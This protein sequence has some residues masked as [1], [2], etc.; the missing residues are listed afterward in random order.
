MWHIALPDA[1]PTHQSNHIG[2]QS[3]ADLVAFAHATLYSPVL[4]TLEKALNIGWLTN[5][6]GLSTHTLRKHPP[7]STSTTKGHMDQARMNQRS[8]RKVTTIKPDTDDPIHGTDD[9][10]PEAIPAKTFE[11]FCAITEPTGQIYTDQTGRFISPSSTGNNYLMILYDYDSNHIFA[12][13]MKNQQA[14]TIVDAYAILHARLCKDGLKPRLQR[15]DNECSALLKE[16]MHANDVDFQLVPPG[17]H[18]RNA[19]KRA[20]RTFKNHFIAGL[21]SVDKNFPM[22]LWDKLIPQAEITL[23][24]LRGSRINPKLSA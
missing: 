20:I 8:T 18:R 11:C 17:I 4:G 15:L 21:C 7:A 9:T 12:Q 10:T 19:A 3:T 23:N 6:P 1:S 2:Q 22:H 16:Y 5:F 13:P 14:E 24:L